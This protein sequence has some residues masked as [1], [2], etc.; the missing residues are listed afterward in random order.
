MKTPNRALMLLPC[1]KSGKH[2]LK[3]I[4]LLLTNPNV[5]DLYYINEGY[6]HKGNCSL[7]GGIIVGKSIAELEG[8]TNVN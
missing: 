8:K 3:N 5:S 6:T 7:C 1:E 2:V 4:V